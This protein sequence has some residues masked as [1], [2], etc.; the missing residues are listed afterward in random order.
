MQ[1]LLLAGGLPEFMS[2]VPSAS[3]VA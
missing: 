2:S 1:K 3:Q